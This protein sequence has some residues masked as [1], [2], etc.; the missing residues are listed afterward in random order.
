MKALKIWSLCSLFTF[1]PLTLY[2]SSLLSD[3]RTSHTHSHPKTFAVSCIYMLEITVTYITRLPS[4]PGASLWLGGKASTCN[5]GDRDSIP[6]LGKF[7]GEENGNPLQDFCLG[8]PMDIGAS[9]ATIHGVA[10]EL[11]TT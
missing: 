10:K 11:D 3:R 1:L 5:A 2:I 8:N 9:C 4:S 6:E 7:P